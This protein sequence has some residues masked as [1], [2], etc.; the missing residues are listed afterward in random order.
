MRQVLKIGVVYSNFVF[1]LLIVRTRCQCMLL[2]IN[3]AAW[4][5]SKI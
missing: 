3:L 1:F 2:L 4:F 5:V